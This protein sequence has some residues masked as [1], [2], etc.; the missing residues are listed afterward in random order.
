[1]ANRKKVRESNQKSY[2]KYWDKHQDKNKKW[3]QNNRKRVVE[4]VL[5]SREKHREKFEEYQHKFNRSSMGKYRFF[6]SRHITRGYEGKVI[7]LEEYE[8]IVSNPCVYCG[9]SILPRGIDRID[10]SKGYIKNNSAP[11]CKICNYMKKTYS[12]KEFLNHIRKINK[13]SP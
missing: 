1:M 6:K 13:Y 8:K 4:I 7:T 11:C 9:E 12:V 3:A 5:A 2:R 10:N